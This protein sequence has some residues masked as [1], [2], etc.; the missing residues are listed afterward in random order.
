[1]EIT[2]L[3]G[4]ATERDPDPAAVLSQTPC[5]SRVLWTGQA[6]GGG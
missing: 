1:M 4:Y 5:P 3:F 6:V 2:G